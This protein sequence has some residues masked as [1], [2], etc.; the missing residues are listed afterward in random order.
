MTAITEEARALP[1]SGS[2]DTVAPEAFREAMTRFASSVTVVTAYDGAV[3]VGCT[4]TAVFSLT[5]RPP[6]LLVSLATGSTT[7]G[8]IRAAGRFAVNVLPWRLRGLAERFA[9]LPSAQRFEGVP[10]TARFGAPL[11]D[12]AVAAM[13][14]R[15]TQ[16]VPLAD[17]TLVIGEVVHAETDQDG[18]PLVHF[19]RRQTRPEA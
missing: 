6:A 3:P 10:H 17:H 7:L 19:A 8:N 5:D 11:L 16:Y 1:S 13:A 2:A 14:C 4:A 15:V 18:Q 9:V 12:G